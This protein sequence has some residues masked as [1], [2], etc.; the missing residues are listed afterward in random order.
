MP[1]SYHQ[2][3]CYFDVKTGK[4]WIDTTDTAAGRLAINSSFF[5]ICAAD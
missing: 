1:N 5:G 3:Y 2:G 4:F